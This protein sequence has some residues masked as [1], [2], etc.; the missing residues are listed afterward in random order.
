MNL[1]L[2]KL[3]AAAAALVLLTLP[4]PAAAAQ[5]AQQDQDGSQFDYAAMSA[6][7][8]QLNA[9]L[10]RLRADIDQS[11]FDP[12]SLVDK[13]DYDADALVGFVR[14]QVAFQ[15]YDGVLRGVA[16]TLRA[17]AG[18]S[19]D[20]AL[21][22]G[23]LLKSAGYDVRV[24]R[25][26][27]GVDDAL[28]MLRGLAGTPAPESLDY[29]V[30]SLSREFPQAAASP[31]KPVDP[32]KTRAADL[33]RVI[34]KQLLARLKDA[35]ISLADSDVQARLL[36]PLQAYFWVQYRDGPSKPWQDAHPAFGQ[37][38]PPASVQVQEAFTEA[39]PE[40]FQQTLTVAA[41]IE[42]YQAGKIVPHALMKP[43]T[44]PVA[45]LG[46]V[47][48][49]YRNFPSGLS[50]SD[51]GDLDKV[52]AG[53]QILIPLFNGG[54]PPGAM[55]F[56]LKGRVIDPM[57][58]GSGT[59]GIFK[60]MADA[61]DSAASQLTGPDGGQPLQALRSMW[62]E[63]TFRT[64]S[65]SSQTYRRYVLTPRSDHSGDP[66]A[67]VLPLLADHVYMVNTGSEPLD[68]LA[69]RYLQAGIDNH[70]W[71]QAMLQKFRDPAAEVKFPKQDMPAGFAPLAQYWFM[72]SHPLGDSGI[73]RFRASPSLIGLRQG[74]RDTHTAFAAVDV[75]THGVEHLR[76]TDAGIEQLPR[77]TLARGIWDT[78]VESIPGRTMVAQPL[79][80]TGTAK[81]L[82]MAQQQ[83]IEI[84][85]LQPGDLSGLATLQFD[86]AVKGFIQADL[87]R[88]LAV[89]APVKVPEGAD[90]AAWW[91][92]DPVSG[93]TLGM[94]GDSHG[95]EMVEFLTDMTSIAFNMV[96][97]LQAL[98]DCNKLDNDVAKMCCLVE[99]NINN[100]A[101][102]GMGSLMGATVG[103]AGGAL[104]D[105]LNFATTEA[106][107]RAFG[108]G[109]GLMPTAKLGCE[110]MQAAGF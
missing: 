69:D 51:A 35:G 13:L 98:K 28:H 97:A 14:D 71:L 40:Q 76:R 105:I 1:I 12:D 7:L 59:A 32:A 9:K 88:G 84:R 65:G 33:T 93:E 38:D 37:A 41:F 91:S 85:V 54:Q 95:Q 63:F 80:V 78:V 46:G 52:V 22:L 101:G 102:L 92:I 64:P 79:P 96:Q 20:Q 75:V 94:T 15:P 89:V 16:G 44:R 72:D 82:G 27:L 108:E 21:L 104:F 45:N 25:G 103:T 73:I 83:G 74:F 67:L 66:A 48:L 18:N 6:Q 11:R 110:K 10:T 17:R 47:P 19:I 109:V 30:P 68:F 81:V 107:S 53:T 57:V 58:V 26:T 43:W 23:Y 61:L 56:D 106:T 3:G 42:Q 36:E 60:T 39:I 5:Q 100:V 62:L 24:V 29:L 86:P 31:E 49:R 34:Q 2:S 55:A 99:A 87:E 8:D 50:A 4:S 70:E 77:T 90:Q